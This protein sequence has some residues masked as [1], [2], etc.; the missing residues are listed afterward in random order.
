MTHVQQMD[1]DPFWSLKTDLTGVKTRVSDQFKVNMIDTSF[2]FDVFSTQQCKLSSNRKYRNLCWNVINVCFSLALSPQ[3]R[4]MYFFSQSIRNKEFFLLSVFKS[5]LKAKNIYYIYIL[6]QVRDLTDFSG[7]L[8][9]PAAGLIS[10]DMDPSL[11]KLT[12]SNIR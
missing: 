1:D 5:L 9:T 4:I 12:T 7:F 6:F 11:N 3:I 2:M 10:A 8:D